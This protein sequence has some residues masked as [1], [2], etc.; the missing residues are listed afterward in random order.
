MVEKGESQGGAPHRRVEAVSRDAKLDRS[1]V[2]VTYTD[3][4]I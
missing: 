2:Q 1:L 3:I 4:Q